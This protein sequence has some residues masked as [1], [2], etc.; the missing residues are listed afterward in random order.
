MAD[1]TRRITDALQRAEILSTQAIPQAA[2][3]TDLAMREADLYSTSFEEYVADA[4]LRAQDLSNLYTG[5]EFM[6]YLEGEKH[7][8]YVTAFGV[9]FDR[10][11]DDLSLAAAANDARVAI[12]VIQTGGLAGPGPISLT[13]MGTMTA[14]SILSASPPIA[15][16]PSAIPLSRLKNLETLSELTGGIASTTAYAARGFDRINEATRTGYLLAYY[17]TNARWDGK[18][19]KIVVKVDRP[20][21]T[22]LF[23]HGYYGREQL[24]PL[25][26]RSFITFNRVMAA[27]AEGSELKALAV[28]V[29]ASAGADQGAAATAY[30]GVLVDISK[31][32]FSQVGDRR[33]ASLAVTLFCTDSKENLIGEAW[34][35]ADL[36]LK[37]E[38]YQRLLKDGYVHRAQ[39]P[40]KGKAKL[41][42]VKAV[43]YDYAADAVGSAIVRVK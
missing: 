27:G 16:R 1:D 22:V 17:P 12:D 6:R 18:Y 25:D 37:E 5:I 39:V 3:V 13:G 43:V 36:A 9:R 23:R 21:L 19:R 11:E 10:L 34:Q 30:V 40:L 7:L 4:R 42:W 28:R 8:V 24:L 14:G 15:E 32:S 26:R 2:L 35:K 41:G 31:V 38:T 29:S 33:V 20:G